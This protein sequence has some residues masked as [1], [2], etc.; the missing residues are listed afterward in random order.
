F[1]VT[2]V[3]TCALPISAFDERCNPKGAIPGDH[4]C[5]LIR[6]A[7][8][9]EGKLA[10]VAA[11]AAFKDKLAIALG[12]VQHAVVDNLCNRDLA[13]VGLAAGFEIYGLGETDKIRIIGRS[14]I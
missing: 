6:L 10:G 11:M 9:G 8:R 5:R 7:D 14:D 2:G 12:W 3:Q 13:A 4:I 1:H